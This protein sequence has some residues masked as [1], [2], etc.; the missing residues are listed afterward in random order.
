MILFIIQ[1][2]TLETSKFKK[3]PLKEMIHDNYRQYYNYNDDFICKL[4]CKTYRLLPELRKYNIILPYTRSLEETINLRRNYYYHWYDYILECP[5]W[6][7]RLLDCGAIINNNKFTFDNVDC[8]E[9]FYERYNYEPD[10]Q[11]LYITNM[12]LI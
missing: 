2:K 12:L 7:S 8:E 1:N 4:N 5:L 3:V 9:V 10:E 11:K 6:R